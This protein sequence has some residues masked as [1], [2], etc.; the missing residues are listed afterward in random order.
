MSNCNVTNIK[1]KESEIENV[2]IIVQD[3]CLRW[4]LLD[5]EYSLSMTMSSGQM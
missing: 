4:M 1:H 2:G 3:N 5:P